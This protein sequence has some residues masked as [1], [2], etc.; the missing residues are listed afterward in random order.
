MGL[1]IYYWLHIIKKGR[2]IHTGLELQLCH[3]RLVR[4]PNKDFYS[5]INVI[6][7]NISGET[8]P[9]ILLMMGGT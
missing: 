6:F 3:K 9:V 7:L 5:D 2:I 8:A 1:E 4:I